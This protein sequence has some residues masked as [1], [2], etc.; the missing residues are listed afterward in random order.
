MLETY[1]KSL[2]EDYKPLYKQRGMTLKPQPFARS[3]WTPAGDTTVPEAQEISTINE[4]GVVEGKASCC[5][6]ADVPSVQTVE[7]VWLGRPLRKLI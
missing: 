2:A 5:F 3:N 4:Q 1:E 7:V 6:L